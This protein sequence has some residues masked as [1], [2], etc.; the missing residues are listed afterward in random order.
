VA[1]QTDVTGA[2][3]GPGSS[4]EPEEPVGLAAFAGALAGEWDTVEEDMAEIVAARRR[5]SPAPSAASALRSRKR[6]SES[7]SASGRGATIR[8]SAPA[9]A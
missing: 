3:S 9:S 5:H 4:P 7:A 6:S 1:E 8:R 2:A